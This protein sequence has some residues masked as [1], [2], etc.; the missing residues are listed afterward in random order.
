MSNLAKIT[1]TSFQSGVLQAAGPVLVDFSATWCG[2][3]KMLDPILEQLAKDWQGK[4]Q[5]YQVD[6]DEDANLAMQYQ[7]MGVPTVMLFIKGKPVERITGY[8]PKDR[9]VARLSPHLGN[10]LR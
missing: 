2:P 9:L 5:F 1:E 7:V 3:C 10:Q 6:V 4:V 8:N